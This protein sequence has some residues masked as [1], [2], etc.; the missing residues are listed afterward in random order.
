MV[1]VAGFAAY[2]IDLDKNLQEAIIDRTPQSA[3]SAGL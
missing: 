1:R 3:C 2:F